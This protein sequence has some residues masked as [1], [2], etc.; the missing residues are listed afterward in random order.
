MPLPGF[1]LG[2]AVSPRFTQ[3]DEYSVVV[4]LNANDPPEPSAFAG[5]R[6]RPVFSGPELERT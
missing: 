4:E 2:T 5:E 1:R 3:A 6:D